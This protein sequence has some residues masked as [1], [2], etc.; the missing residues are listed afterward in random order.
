MS[1]IYE[2]KIVYGDQKTVEEKIT[3]LTQS[4][5]T[6]QGNHQAFPYNGTVMFSQPMIKE[7]EPHGAW[8]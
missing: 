4:G 1:R 8:G 6:I 3:L 5:W 7:Y 2:Y